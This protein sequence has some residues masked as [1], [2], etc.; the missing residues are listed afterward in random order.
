MQIR[1]R[2]ANDVVILYIV[3]NIDVNSA[4]FIEQT[5]RLLKDGTQ[6]IL[7]NFTNVNLVDYNGLSILVIAYKNAINQKG[8]LKFCNIPPHIKE[9]FKIARLDT[10]FDIY[11]D[12]KNALQSFRLSTKVDKLLLRRRFKR[13]DINIP[14]RYKK[15]LSANT[16]L[17]K[18]KIL[19]ISGEG[20]FIHSKN[21]FPVSTQLYLEIEFGKKKE[22][23]TLMGAV[24][25]LADKKL[26]P[27]AYPGMGISF[28]NLD[29][30]NQIKI[31]DFIDKNIT[32]R[33]QV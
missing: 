1:K 17:V 25:W 32:R 4:E 21:T 8:I 5:G 26:Q 24:I 12:E 28:I 27:H 11:A 29:K 2:F 18:G 3:G 9:L 30:K 10:V 20:L 23:L 31:I 16:K 33:S 14:V 6:K 22:L 7:C 15:G 19:N 13:I